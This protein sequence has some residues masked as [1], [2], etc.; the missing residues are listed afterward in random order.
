MNEGVFP[1]TRS[2]EYTSKVVTLTTL[3][4][5]LMISI[6]LC[7]RYRLLSATTKTDQNCVDS[8][9]SYNTLYLAK[10]YTLHKQHILQKINDI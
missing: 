9:F 2:K 3:I 8:T 5:D 4:R 6:L 10:I 1:L 7:C